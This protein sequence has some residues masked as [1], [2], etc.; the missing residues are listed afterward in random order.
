MYSAESKKIS[1]EDGEMAN[2]E[3]SKKL[4]SLDEKAVAIVQEYA[5]QLGYGEAYGFSQTLR[6]IIREWQEMKQEQAK[7]QSRQE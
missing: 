2:G 5:E 1:N 6:I 3:M 7:D 4:V